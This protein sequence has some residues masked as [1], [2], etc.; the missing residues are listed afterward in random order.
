[1]TKDPC[2][3]WRL[4]TYKYLYLVWCLRLIMEESGAIS[5]LRVLVGLKR[6]IKEVFGVVCNSIVRRRRMVK[7]IYIIK[8]R[9]INSILFLRSYWK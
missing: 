6:I 2:K 7:S 3:Y 8:H 5:V 1:M 4:C 9:F